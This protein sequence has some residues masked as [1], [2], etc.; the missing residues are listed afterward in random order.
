MKQATSIEN[1]NTLHLQDA[2]ERAIMIRLAQEDVLSFEMLVTEV[3]K[4]RARKETNVASH[5]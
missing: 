4:Y 3:R 5:Q 1:A 2:Q